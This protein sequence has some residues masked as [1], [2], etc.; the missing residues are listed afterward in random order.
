MKCIMINKISK[1]IGIKPLNC[2]YRIKYIEH[3]ITSYCIS[4][5]ATQELSELKLN[6]HDLYR[7]HNVIQYV[8][9]LVKNFEKEFIENLFEI[10]TMYY[11]FM[12]IFNEV[13]FINDIGDYMGINELSNIIID[14]I[15]LFS[16]PY[17]ELNN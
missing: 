4:V 2:Y 15:N 11:Y 10:I 16:K 12:E 9:P 7:I 14:N 6:T 13:Y 17:F 1:L 8:L 3:C 5:K